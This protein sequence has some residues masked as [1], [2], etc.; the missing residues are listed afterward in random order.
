MQETVQTDLCE[1]RDNNILVKLTAKLR[2]L[3]VPRF[4]KFAVEEAPSAKAVAA[5]E[6]H[7]TPALVTR[8]ISERAVWDSSEH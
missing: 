1:K 8:G 4:S 6:T 3:S 7:F 2:V 5:S